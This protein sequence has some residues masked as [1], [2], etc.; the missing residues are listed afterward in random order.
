M[1]NRILLSTS[2]L[3]LF[4]G[5]GMQPNTL[6]E[7]SRLEGT[8]PNSCYVDGKPPTMMTTYTG[9]QT[10]VGPWEMYQGPDDKMYLVL[11]DKKTIIEGT[12]NDTF[13]FQW[14]VTTTD[15]EPPP[16]NVT[17]TDAVAN[18]VSFKVDGATL[19]GTWEL[20]ETHA[21]NGA[22]CTNPIPNCTVTGQL[23]G[24]QLDVDRYKV[25]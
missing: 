19:S 12:H 10:N 13:N 7:V 4:A 5:C 17:V 8:R 24:R 14:T 18:T 23:K 9:V 22:G 3:A 16:V 1:L 11:A 2:L 15:Q 20:K 6:W 21:C 25:Y